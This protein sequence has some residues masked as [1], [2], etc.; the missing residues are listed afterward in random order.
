MN[1][2]EVVEELSE[3]CD[4]SKAAANRVVDSILDGIADGLRN[5]DEVNFPGFGKFVTQD[6]KAREAANPR[7]RSQT[8]HIAAATVPKFRAGTNLRSAVE[9]V[10]PIQRARPRPAASSSRAGAT[11]SAG[12]KPLAARA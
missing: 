9:N 1:K 4:F 7:D 6:R 10:E 12:W 11:D 2:Q 5:G 3:R 8:V